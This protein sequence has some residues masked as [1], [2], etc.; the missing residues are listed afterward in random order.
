MTQTDRE[1]S[2]RAPLSQAVVLS[3]AVSLADRE[4]LDAVTI[5]RLAQ[6][7]GVT[8]MALY[9]HFRNK[10]L[11]LAALGDRIF[12]EV[13]LTVDPD[14]PWSTQF[15]TL[16]RALVTTLRKHP[17]AGSVFTSQIC[18]SPSYLAALEK[19]L[20][21]LRGAGFSPAEATDISRHAMSTAMSLVN[22]RPGSTEQLA[23]DEAEDAQRRARLHFEALPRK[24]YPHIVEAAGPL[25]TCEDQDSSYEFGLDLLV[26][27]VEAM[28]ARKR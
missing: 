14:A 11:L 24:R 1:A 21:I 22:S 23:P 26:A 16:I 19:V 7:L 15:R 12:G 4:G 2:G 8:P 18:E 6:D 27:G 17:W 25:T 13:D 20:A 3:E 9:W 28:A 5:R 10:G